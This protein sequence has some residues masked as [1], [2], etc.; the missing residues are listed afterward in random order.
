MHRSH[1]QRLTGIV[2]NEKPNIP[3]EE[4][5]RLKAVLTNCVR[6]GPSSQNREG[7]RDFRAHL[8]GRVAYVASLNA[9]RGAK[10]DAIY[11]RIEWREA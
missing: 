1:R 7:V 9:D 4:F 8:A 6:H 2:V 10:L 3:R 5:D 11:R